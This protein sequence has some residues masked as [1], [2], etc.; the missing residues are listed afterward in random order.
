MDENILKFFDKIN[1]VISAIITGI[2][3]IF[4][5]QW[6]LFAGYLILNI[7]DFITGC[8]KARINRIES[9]IIGSKGILKKS[10]LLAINSC[11][12]FIFLYD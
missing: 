8:I 2:T 7:L 6:I 12:F 4:G 5:I 11:S 9:S 1:L 3:N 10:R